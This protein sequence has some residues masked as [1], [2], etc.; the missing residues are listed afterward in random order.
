[1]TKWLARAGMRV[2]VVDRAE[3]ASKVAAEVGALATPVL[4]DLADRA[5]VERIKKAPAKR[6]SAGRG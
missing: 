5:A 4:A 1:M 3:T 6:G 2:C